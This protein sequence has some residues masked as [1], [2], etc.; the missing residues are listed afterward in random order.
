MAIF[1]PELS[2]VML[3]SEKQIDIVMKSVECQRTFIRLYIE[4]HVYV[5]WWS[6]HSLRM[7]IHDLRATSCIEVTVTCKYMSA[8][9]DT[10]R[11]IQSQRGSNGEVRHILDCWL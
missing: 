7:K 8:K 1:L 11:S 4:R 5:A 6:G 3:C 10:S 2:G 9:L